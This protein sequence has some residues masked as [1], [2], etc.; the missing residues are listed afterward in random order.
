[1]DS[2]KP[3][4]LITGASSG[5]G[6]CTALKLIDLGYI[7]YGAARR[8]ELMQPIKEA[9]GHILSLDF[10]NE[11]SVRECVNSIIRQ[12]GR[13]DVLINNA[14]FG[15]GGNIESVSI[16]EA[17]KQFEVNVFGLSLI[18]CENRNPAES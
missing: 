6:L 4:A 5:I 16:Q 3:V 1:M 2:L 15:L 12:S 17:K 8:L 14:G 11:N 7:V 10:Y 9:G 18:T 13:I